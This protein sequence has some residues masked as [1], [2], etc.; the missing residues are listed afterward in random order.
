MCEEARWK[1]NEPARLKVKSYSLQPVQ[2]V[3]RRYC[4]NSNVDQKVV[5]NGYS[6][7]V[8]Y[9]MRN[10]SGVA[11]CGNDY[12]IVYRTDSPRKPNSLTSVS[13]WLTELPRSCLNEGSGRSLG[14]VMVTLDVASS[15]GS[16]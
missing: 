14:S 16:L 4:S 2:A 6:E 5:V 15:S 11:T 7:E 13:I 12:A 10:E 1:D 9:V 3:G 8:K